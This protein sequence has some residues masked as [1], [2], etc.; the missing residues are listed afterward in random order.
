MNTKNKNILIKKINQSI[1]WH[2]TPRDPDAYKKRGKFL[3]STYQQAEFYGRPNDIPEKVNITNPVY[4][5]SETNILKILF[6]MNYKKLCLSD[7]DDRKDWYKRRITLDAKM[8]KK[9]QKMG[10]DAIVL[11]GSSANKYLMKNRKPH[12]IELNLC[13]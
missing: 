6:P 5:T 13:K 10:Y 11:L 3:A 1:W 12:S 4:G 8:Y 7:L 2:V 9:A